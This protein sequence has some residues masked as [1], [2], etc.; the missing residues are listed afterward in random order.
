MDHAHVDDGPA[1]SDVIKQSVH[2]FY[3]HDVIGFAL[4]LQNGS[5]IM[6]SIITNIIKSQREKDVLSSSYYYYM[7]D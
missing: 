1:L 4:L 7:F 5:E 3:S 6:T 2:L